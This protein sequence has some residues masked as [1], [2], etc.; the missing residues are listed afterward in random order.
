MPQGMSKRAR[1]KSS[2]D[3]RCCLDDGGLGDVAVWQ[4]MWGRD[5]M[6]VTILSGG[7]Y[8]YCVPMQ[9]SDVDDENWLE[10]W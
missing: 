7:W 6:D 3:R 5:G 2:L 9:L 8:V 10:S 1:A 4:Q